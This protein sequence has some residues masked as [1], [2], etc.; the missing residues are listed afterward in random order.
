LCAWSSGIYLQFTK[1]PCHKIG[2]QAVPLL[3]T[4]SKGDNEVFYSYLGFVYIEFT[5]I[6]TTMKKFAGILLLIIAVAMIYIGISNSIL[7]PPLTGI[8]FILIAL[9]FLRNNT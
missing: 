2:S 1:L 7:A 4:I 6:K 8:G 5:F 3:S 9:V